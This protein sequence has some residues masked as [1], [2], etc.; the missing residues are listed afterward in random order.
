MF[1]AA[2]TPEDVADV[3]D[4]C[5]IVGGELPEGEPVFDLLPPVVRRVAED[6]ERPGAGRVRLRR[7]RTALD[8]EE[9]GDR[10][11]DRGASG[12][13]DAAHAWIV[14]HPVAQ[15]EGAQAPQSEI[16]R[17]AQDDG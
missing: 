9:G 7:L 13:A 3:N 5:E 11:D 15:T 2:R 10:D 8:E 1:V 14:R 4:E 12:P 6:R 17:C 16:L